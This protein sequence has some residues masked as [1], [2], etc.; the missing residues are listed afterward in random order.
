MLA[1][2]QAE[3]QRQAVSFK[4]VLVATDFSDVSQAAQL[5]G[6]AIARRC[7]SEVYF[8]HASSPEARA[9]IPM[10]SL[11]KEIDR[12][13]IEAE[14]EMKML[15]GQAQAEGIASHTMVRQGTAS[16]VIPRIIQEAGID[17]LVLGTHGRG[18]WKKLVLGSVAEELLRLVSCP[19]LTVGP[20]VAPAASARANFERVLFATDF[21]PGATK[22]L[23]YAL[24]LAKQYS[25]RLVLLHMVPPIPVV[26]IGLESYGAAKYTAEELTNEESTVR[27]ESK[28]RLKQLLLPE[29]EQ[30]FEPEYVVASDFLPEGILDVAAERK[31]GLIVMGAT[32]PRSARAAAHI[33]WTV[34]HHVLSEAQCPVFT[35]MA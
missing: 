34:V 16:A 21:G 5:W 6:L 13:Q 9:A 33:P 28:R 15:A 23:P 20:N 2:A 7:G 14:G 30:V 24:F 18:G 22:A 26:Q 1:T 8:A 10:D 35:V 12:S 31:A 19:V 4:R 17:L 3:A 11:P 32:R 27:Q 29:T 25:A